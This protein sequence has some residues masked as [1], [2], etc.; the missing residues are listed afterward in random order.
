MP[1]ILFYGDGGDEHAG[2]ALV[3]LLRG[4]AYTYRKASDPGADDE[5]FAYTGSDATPLPTV[6]AL[7]DGKDPKVLV[8]ATRGSLPI[9]LA[10]LTAE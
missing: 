4:T 7:K 10:S 9:F 6:I 5:L 3:L 8:G 1:E 2:I